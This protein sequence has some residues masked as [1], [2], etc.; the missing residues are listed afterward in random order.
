VA[1]TATFLGAVHS[2]NGSVTTQSNPITT[3]VSIPSGALLVVIG[4]MADNGA[5][6]APTGLSAVG[7]LTFTQDLYETATGFDANQ[8]AF[9]YSA[10]AP[11][12]LA[13][14]SNLIMNFSQPISWGVNLA[15]LYLTGVDTGSSRVDNADATFDATFSAAQDWTLS[16]TTAVCALVASPWVDGSSGAGFTWDAPWSELDDHYDSGNSWQ[17]SVA[18]M[19]SSS[20]GVQN[21]GG[22]W[23]NAPN[24]GRSTVFIAYKETGTTPS[25]GFVF[26]HRVL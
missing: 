2:F 24:W 5:G 20:S 14:G 25:P 4:Q 9:V 26:A 7:G 18:F 10:P 13:S 23:G 12:G 3:S 1:A 6:I 16:I 21:A 11:S 22:D 19:E 8:R 15:A 17:M